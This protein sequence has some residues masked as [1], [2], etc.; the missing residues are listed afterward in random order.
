[1]AMILLIFE[2]SSKMPPHKFNLPVAICGSL[3]AVLLIAIIV[4]AHDP[5]YQNLNKHPLNPLP[6][7]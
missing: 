6:Y 7:L 5:P 2:Q 3:L 4:I 1:M